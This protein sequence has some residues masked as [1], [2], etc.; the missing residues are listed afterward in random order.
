MKVAKKSDA[1][2]YKVFIDLK[3]EILE[4]YM[5]G[6]EELKAC[7]KNES[8]NLDFSKFQGDNDQSL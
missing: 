4:Y 5:G 8:P 2:E 6:F 3:K 7:V 1:G